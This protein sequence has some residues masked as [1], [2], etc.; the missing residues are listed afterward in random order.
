MIYDYIIVGGGVIGCSILNKLTRLNKKCLLIEK[1]SDV[2]VGTSKANSGIVHAGFDAMPGTLKATLNVKGAKVFEA[3]CKELSVPYVK[4]GAIVVGN[5]KSVMEELYK[6]GQKNG[7]DGLEIINHT[8]LRKLCPNINEDIK[9]ALYA[10]T[11]AIVSPYK[12]T[13]A[14]AEEAVINGA[15]VV[16]DYKINNVNYTEQGVEISG[17]NEKFVGKQ[18]VLAVGNS[19]N[20]VASIFDTKKY[21]IVFRRGE[22]YLLDKGSLDINGLTIFPIP[23]KRDGKGVLVSGTKWYLADCNSFRSNCST[24]NDC[25]NIILVPEVIDSIAC[26]TIS[27]A[28]NNTTFYSQFTCISNG[29]GGVSIGRIRCSRSETQLTSFLGTTVR[30][31]QVSRV[32]NHVTSC[33]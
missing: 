20:E 21:D 3:R 14:L 23:S 33:T 30:D 1:G 15:D 27:I 28:F 17:N 9:Y 31:C 7:V 24:I 2:A 12:L 26:T 29:T 4:N 22:Y 18:V 13:I 11:S 16:F 8:Q 19:H 32:L 6:R 5:D 25:F 10:K